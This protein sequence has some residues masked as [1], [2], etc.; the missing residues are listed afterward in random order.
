MNPASQR[1]V[2]VR[3]TVVTLILSIVILSPPRRLRLGL[4]AACRP[5][6]ECCELGPCAIAGRTRHKYLACAVV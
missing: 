1:N 6:T 3:D 5:D 2:I 4:I